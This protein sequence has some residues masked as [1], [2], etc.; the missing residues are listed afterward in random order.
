M[1]KRAGLFA[2]TMLGASAAAFA[3]VDLDSLGDGSRD[4]G[5]NPADAAKG[6]EDASRD[7]AASP[8]DAAPDRSAYL[9]AAG[10][11]ILV[12]GGSV[13]SHTTLFAPIL[14]D[15][16]IGAWSSGPD[17]P[18]EVDR[19][20][21]F[22]LGD[23]VHVFGG[24]T[25]AEPGGTATLSSSRVLADGGFAP[26]TLSTLSAAVSDSCPVVVGARDS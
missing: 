26:F 17:L 7:D 20:G 4:A 5:P 11:D 9:F 19:H 15:G 22:G 21:V 16:A 25:V 18:T 2:V 3:C 13:R 12:D 1:T 14:A 10:G 24:S 23:S 8:V 6:V